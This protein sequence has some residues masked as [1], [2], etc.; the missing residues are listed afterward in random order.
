VPTRIIADLAREL[1]PVTKKVPEQLKMKV[2]ILPKLPTTTGTPRKRRMAS[3][4]EAVLEFVKMPPSSSVE[5]S[6][7]KT[8]E[9]PKIITVGLPMPKR[10]L[11]KSYQK[12]IRKRA[13]QKNL[14]CLL[15]KH[16]PRVTWTISFDML[17]E[18]N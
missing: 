11:R 6:G 4:L 9:V 16:L 8:K 12:I 2:T 1:E 15:P 17:R 3:V 18:S 14:R 13:F 7:S 5:A 10:V